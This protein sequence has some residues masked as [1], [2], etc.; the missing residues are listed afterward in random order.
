MNNI[1]FLQKFS[2]HVVNDL[3]DLSLAI[4]KLYI[5]LSEIKEFKEGDDKLIR[6]AIIWIVNYIVTDKEGMLT[7]Y[8]EQEIA[9]K[10]LEEWEEDLMN[11][12][13]EKHVVDNWV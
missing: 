11:N 6:N 2:P 4:C 7:S 3:E 1:E 8:L 5:D 10:R 13:V 9:N 12:K